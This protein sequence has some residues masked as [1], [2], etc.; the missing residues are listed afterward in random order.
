MNEPSIIPYIPYRN[1]GLFDNLFK[2]KPDE[3]QKQPA[4]AA[5]EDPKKPE[6]VDQEAES[7][8]MEEDE[9]VASVAGDDVDGEDPI[10]P[11]MMKKIKKREQT[12]ESLADPEYTETEYKK[13]KKVTNIDELLNK[14][15]KLLNNVRSQIDIIDDIQVRSSGVIAHNVFTY[16]KHAQ[17]P[18]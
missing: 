13:N 11:E 4:S 5:A 7:S 15:P 3:P 10:D 9:S 16:Y 14:S 18:G 6:Q 8:S 1:Y 2:K 12:L 17:V